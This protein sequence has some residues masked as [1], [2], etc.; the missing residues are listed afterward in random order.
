MDRAVLKPRPLFQRLSEPHLFVCA[1]M[2]GLITKRH[3][4]ETSVQRVKVFFCQ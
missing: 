3:G 4:G 2:T 1:L